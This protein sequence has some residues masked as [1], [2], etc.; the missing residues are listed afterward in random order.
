M[1]LDRRIIKDRRKKP[2]PLISRYSLWGKR[3]AF[4]R[5]EDKLK[6]GYVD[7]YHPGMLFFLVLLAG[8]NIVDAL[9]TLMILDQG[10]WEVN[11]V[12]HSVIT[13]LG[14]NFWIWK[15]SMVSI[16]LVLLCMHSKFKVVKLSILFITLIYIGLL[17][18]HIRLIIS[19]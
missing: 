1:Q 11:P 7:R 14:D 9:F 2:T 5:K 15:F 8:L 6:G 10:G 12:V 17:L 3:K 4:R 16:S 13:I 19:F 18:H